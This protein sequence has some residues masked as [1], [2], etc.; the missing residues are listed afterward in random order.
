MDRF[1]HQQGMQSILIILLFSSLFVGVCTA[2]LSPEYFAMRRTDMSLNDE[3]IFVF[4]GRGQASMRDKTITGIQN[5][6]FP[7]VGVR[8]KVWKS[9]HEVTPNVSSQVFNYL[10]NLNFRDKVTNI[11][12]NDALDTLYD[13][14]ARYGQGC[15]PLG[16]NFNPGWYFPSHH[17]PLHYITVR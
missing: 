1:L 11:I 9:L 16:D 10:F 17:I 8:L 6:L 12:I 3:G 4:N 5:V 2:D 14:F 7:P 13:T 15:H